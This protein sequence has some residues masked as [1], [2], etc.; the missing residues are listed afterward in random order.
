VNTDKKKLNVTASV[1]EA[2]CKLYEKRRSEDL[3]RSAAALML[4]AKLSQMAY[5]LAESANF[6]K[7]VTYQ[8]YFADIGEILREYPKLLLRV[9]ELESKTQKES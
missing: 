4:S 3:R 6:D 8:N 9:A 1:A 2:V 5:E 7:Q